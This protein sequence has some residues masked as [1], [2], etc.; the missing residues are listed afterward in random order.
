VRPRVSV[1][2]PT[3]GQAHFI[4]RAIESL[5]RQSYGRWELVVVDD[6]SPDATNSAVEPYLSDERIR[7][8]RCEE[9]Q[10]LGAALNA[11]LEL[12]GAPYIAY[13]PSDDVYF[14]EHLASLVGLLDASP[15]AVLAFSGVRHTYNRSTPGQIPGRS[16]QLVQVLHRRTPDRWLE[17]TA[18]VTDNLDRMYWSALYRRGSVVGTGLVSAEW[19]AHPGQLHRLLHEPEGGINTYRFHFGVRHKLPGRTGCLP[20]GPVCPLD[21]PG[22]RRFHT[23]W[24]LCGQ[25]PACLV[26]AVTAGDQQRSSAVTARPNRGRPLSRSRGLFPR[27]SLFLKAHEVHLPEVVKEGH[28]EGEEQ[29]KKEGIHQTG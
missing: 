3:Y 4:A 18:L 20:G 8:H 25:Q 15:E 5:L 10:G 28:Q 24:L 6:G 21:L 12:A 13:L 29:G 22:D 26:A 11:G 19:V 16:L 23:R 17:R 27:S 7:Y 1:L 2:M 9:N 14:Q